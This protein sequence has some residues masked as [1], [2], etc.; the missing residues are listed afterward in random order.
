MKTVNDVYSMQ[1]LKKKVGCH[2]PFLKSNNSIVQ[3][4][5]VKSKSKSNEKLSDKCHENYQLKILFSYFPLN[6]V[7]V[8]LIAR[9]TVKAKIYVLVLLVQI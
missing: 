1:K 9:Y 7:W 6:I 2:F 3:L 8:A 5:M 4:R